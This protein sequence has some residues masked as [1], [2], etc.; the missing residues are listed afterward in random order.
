M[1][2]RPIRFFHRGAIVEIAAAAP[3]RTVLD[4]LREDAHRRGTKEGCNEGDCGACTVVVGTIAEP[5]AS[6]AVRGLRLETVNA[7]IQF[8]PTLDGKALFTVEDLKAIDAGAPH[9]GR[10]DALHPV[11][12]DEL[13]P[14]QQAMVDCHGSQCGFCTPG[15]V[16]SL[17]SVYEPHMHAGTRPTRQQLA[18]EL[19]GNLCRCTGYRP[20][21]DAGQRM[22]DL[23]AAALDTAPVLAALRAMQRDG[24]L[25][26]AADAA[27]GAEGRFFAPRSLD[28]LAALRA[29]HPK[30]Q[31][32]AGSTDIGLWVNKQ[33]KPLG[34]LIYLGAVDELRR[35]ATTGGDLW[36]GAGASL[37]DA[38]RAL[39]ARWASLTEVWLRF[40]SPPIRH[41][42]TMGGNVANGSP[43]GD[44]A[45]VL[46][47]LDAQLELRHGARTRRLALTDFYVDYMKNRLEPG[48]F[49]Q[50]IVVPA[51][52]ADRVVRAYKISKRFDCDI[53][54]L[55]AGFAIELDGDVVRAVR[56]AFGGMAAIV[57][58][59]AQ[60]EAALV[61]RRW[62][63]AAL[64]DAQAA[65]AN[66][67]EPLTDMR[68][69]AGYRQQVAR[70]LL[71][72]FW[73]ET[74]RHDPL[75]ANATSVWSVM[76]HAPQPGLTEPT[77]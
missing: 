25:A 34:D 10:D 19:S 9:A 75:G 21:L 30:A 68:A 14:V 45:P 49:V 31:L 40:A 53:S 76:P 72:R 5:G 42:G 13:H 67:F 11:R 4:W 56:L 12:D 59:A 15:F 44:S 3:T 51:L 77:P 41:A 16:M 57:K 1:T 61:G 65:L 22:F 54:A 39:A 60:A 66:D 35:I 29:Q 18:D 36:I 58:R 32:L 38:W 74:R 62:D 33:F 43:I 8:L 2:T 50:A 73:L 23:P 46:M 6:N 69:S 28:A 48:E 47:A 20:I 71:Q 70:N 24:D 63:E 64:R 55:C 17:W 27:D 37:E 52:P 26:Y 7:C